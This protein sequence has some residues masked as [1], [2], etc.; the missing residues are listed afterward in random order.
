M[1][2]TRRNVRGKYTSAKEAGVN[3]PQV[4]YSVSFRTNEQK[5]SVIQGKKSPMFPDSGESPFTCVI[6]GC[7]L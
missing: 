1:F 3:E 4:K 5:T 7:E 6:I 2:L